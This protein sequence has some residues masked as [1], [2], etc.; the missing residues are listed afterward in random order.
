MA[1][2]IEQIQA[3]YQ[4]T[5]TIFENGL[6]AAIAA[7]NSDLAVL[8]ASQ[9]F[10]AHMM[11][12]LI[13]WRR[14]SVHPAAA[15]RQAIDAY[16][17]GYRSLVDRGTVNTLPFGSAQIVAFLLDSEVS[18]P[19]AIDTLQADMLLD[20]LI[21]DRLRGNVDEE[22]WKCGL[23]QLGNLKGTAL[24]VETYRHYES[25]LRASEIDP[26][27][28]KKAEQLFVAR[29]KNGFYTGG[30]DISGGGPYNDMIVDYILAAILKS[31][32][33]TV[34]SIHRWPL[35]SHDHCGVSPHPGGEGDK[36]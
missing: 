17:Q 2:S 20:A 5:V 33:C 27:E 26:E 1:K 8:N 4:K 6:R 21:A 15:F 10:Q 18:S 34:D 11:I 14:G 3:T 28:I 7:R 29:K 23:D 36:R 30:A 13:G 32:S 22:M 25:L 16:E 19:A 24:A 9:V 31:R 12:G 35:N